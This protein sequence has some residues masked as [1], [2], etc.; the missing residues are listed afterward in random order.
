MFLSPND[1]SS[2]CIS[3]SLAYMFLQLHRNL[4]NDLPQGYV[5]TH[6]TAHMRSTHVG[7]ESILKKLKYLILLLKI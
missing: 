3:Y 4:L 7:N 5:H 2:H 6:V 1:L